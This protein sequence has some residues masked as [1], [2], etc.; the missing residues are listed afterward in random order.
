MSNLPD[1][2]QG[3][4]T[5]NNQKPD[6]EQG[7]PKELAEPI[8]QG[9][10]QPQADEYLKQQIKTTKQQMKLACLEAALRTPNIGGTGGHD[11]VLKAAKAYYEFV[12]K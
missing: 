10:A 11:D 5:T 2:E 3:W 12:R 7:E 8:E 4:N 1:S 9:E 6:S